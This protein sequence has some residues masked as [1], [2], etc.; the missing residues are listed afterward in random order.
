MRRME[1]WFFGR[2]RPWIAQRAEGEILE[3]GVGTGID[4]E[5]LAGRG[6]VTG[7]D[8]SEAML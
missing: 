3:V 5:H 1:R 6:S 8:L 2:W 7:V 4:L